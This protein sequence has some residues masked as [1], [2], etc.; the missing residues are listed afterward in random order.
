MHPKSID[1]LLLLVY[2]KDTT[3]RLTMKYNNEYNPYQMPLEDQNDNYSPYKPG[4]PFYDK[5][6]VVIKQVLKYYILCTSQK[7]KWI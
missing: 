2:Q 4:Q 1:L 5:R 7:N 3:L 6:P